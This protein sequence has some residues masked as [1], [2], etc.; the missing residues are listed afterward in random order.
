M[1]HLAML[2]IF[3]QTSGDD[4]GRNRGRDS[5]VRRAL[6]D[7]VGHHAMHEPAHERH[8][9]IARRNVEPTEL[10][11]KDGNDD[12]SHDDACRTGAGRDDHFALSH[13]DAFDKKVERTFQ[14]R[15][16]R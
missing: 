7:A 15:R 1:A 13:G 4:G 14:R 5:D 11:H 3:A 8:V 2:L 16:D 12:R 9:R 6:R 10:Q